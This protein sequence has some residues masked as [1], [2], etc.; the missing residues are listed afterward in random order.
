MRVGY[1]GCVR[2]TAIGLGAR[3]HRDL[4]LGREPYRCLMGVAKL[5]A[6]TRLCAVNLV[7]MSNTSMCLLLQ[8]HRPHEWSRQR[9]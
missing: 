3:R 2:D 6:V 1:H 9:R 4:K 5:L 8:I 7:F